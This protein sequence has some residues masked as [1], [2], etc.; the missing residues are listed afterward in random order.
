MSKLHE[1]HY[2]NTTSHLH[3]YQVIPSSTFTDGSSACCMYFS[4]FTMHAAK[5]H[6]LLGPSFD[7]SWLV[8]I[9]GKPQCKMEDNHW[10][11]TGSSVGEWVC[12]GCSCLK[13]GSSG[14]ICE[15]KINLSI[16]V[17]QSCPFRAFLINVFCQMHDIKNRR[18]Y[19]D[20]SVKIYHPWWWQ[21]CYRNTSQ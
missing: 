2:L 13:I 19:C 1:I 16:K 11:G 14:W 5:P 9:V 21:F 4:S 8:Q 17:V 7:I 10:N 6:R 15:H 20:V 12:I 3:V 18:H